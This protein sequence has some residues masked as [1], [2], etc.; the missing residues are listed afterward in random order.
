MESGSVPLA[1]PVRFRN[2]VDS[3][4]LA[5]PVAHI[6]VQDRPDSRTSNRQIRFAGCSLCSPLMFRKSNNALPGRAGTHSL[7]L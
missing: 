7:S 5:E 6:S 4:A 2:G 1:L 3:F